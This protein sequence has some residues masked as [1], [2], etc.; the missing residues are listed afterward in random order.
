[1][2]A[3]TPTNVAVVAVFVLLSGCTQRTPEA[4]LVYDAAEALGGADNIAEAETLV[5]EGTGQQYRLGQ[6]T[7]PDDELPYWE[8]ED[9][10][11][12]IDLDA[13]RWRITQHRTSFFL[14]G[15]PE[16]AEEHIFGIDGDVAYDI[17]WDGAVR[18]GD[19]QLVLD[20]TDD[21]YHHPATLLKLALT[22]GSTL[23]NLRAAGDD[24]A[25][26]ITSTDGATYALFVDRDSRYPTRI[27]S[28]GYHPVLGDVTLTTEFDDY[29]ETG[30]LGGFGGTR[31]TLPREINARL[32]DFTTW[33]LRVTTDINPGLDGVAAP[34]EARVAALP[35]FQPNIEVEELADGVWRLAGQSHHSVLVELD[36]YLALIEAPQNEARTLAII[37]KARELQPDK[38]LQY[39]VSTHHHFDHSAGIRAA[40][41]EGLTVITHESNEEFY[42][43]LV[44]RP[45]TAQ[46]D[47]LTRNPRELTLELVEGRQVYQLGEGRRSMN[48]ARIQEDQHADAILMV[49]LPRERILI[50][51]DAYS[52]TAE[53]APFAANL[54]SDV[55][56]R[57]WRVERIVPLHG[58]VVEFADLENAVEAAAPR[59]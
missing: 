2:P 29:V 37:A 1:M 38:P 17:A 8:V 7:D 50:E 21:H 6:N 30:G 16:V 49:C 57:G 33:H 35:E 58:P 20:R 42:R 55:N 51:A 41:S 18:R 12:E 39:V 43:E 48:I 44:E 14:T 52:P 22:E 10:R 27:V 9:Y 47:A 34:E 15:R 56:E 24:D 36:D 40:V 45:H 31:L 26:D 3:R 13:A 4:Q 46:P 32:D 23:T 11:R 28:A 19:A 54:L 59:L 25:V 53:A 5:L